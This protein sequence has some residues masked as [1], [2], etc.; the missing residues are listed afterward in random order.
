MKFHALLALSLLVAC[1]LFAQ[2]SQE[3]SRGPDG[4]T[5]YFVDGISVLPVAENHS[6]G[7]AAQSGLVRLRMELS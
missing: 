4:G 7:G 6:R 1:T 2:E 5:Q 3:S